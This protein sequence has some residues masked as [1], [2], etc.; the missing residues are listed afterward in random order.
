MLERGRGWTAAAGIAASL[1]AAFPASGDQSAPPAPA[2]SPAAAPESVG[3]AT[4]ADPV[5]DPDGHGPAMQDEFSPDA[6]YTM[7]RTS[8]D[9]AASFGLLGE[10]GGIRRSLADHGIDLALELTLD[11]AWNT[12]GGTKT[13]FVF[14]GLLDLNLGV[15]T[16]PLLGWKGGRFTVTM[17]SYWQSTNPYGLVND[18]WGWDAIS[19]GI[20]SLTQLAEVWYEQDFLD[21]FL[22]LRFGKQD[23][24]STFAIVPGA[25]A[26]ISS[27][28]TYPG[29]LIQYL[30][31]YPHQAIGADLIV[32][33][34]SWLAGRF[35]WLDGSTNYFDA[36]TQSFWPNT[37]TRGPS[38]F[39][40]NPGSWF[41]ISE[42]DA[43]WSLG[44]T[45]PGAAGVGA[46]WQTGAVGFTVQ[47]GPAYTTDGSE[48]FYVGASQT[49]V[50][51]SGGAD[52]SRFLNVFAQ[53]G[54]GQERSN[55]VSWSLIA[56]SSGTGVLPGREQDQLGV[57]F[58][59]SRFSDDPRVAANPGSWQAGVELFY[60]IQLTPAVSVQPDVQ[61]VW[62]PNGDRSQETALLATL[63]L[64]MSF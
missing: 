35:G 48:G 39:F 36:D 51:L 4:P 60:R 33:P 49:I 9:E 64:Q 24:N 50:N 28:A 57:Q 8:T 14:M 15:R 25:G 59:Y 45:L 16:E 42:I 3:Q 11:N 22:T 46:W 37:G 31:T 53:A 12:R 32:R 52:A 18:Y 62:Q 20:G 40:D 17:L 10:L 7:S 56:G 23:A 29:T 58:N 19:S 1:T 5:P 63:R 30:P 13:G 41:F 44:G 55:P 6:P 38:S 43:T 61:W 26:F 47:P 21:R 34:A 27:A 54:F 2:A